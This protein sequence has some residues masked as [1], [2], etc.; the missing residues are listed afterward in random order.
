MRWTW[1]A[2]AFLSAS[3]LF[4][5]GYYHDPN[6]AVW[7]VLVLAGTGLLIGIDFRT[8]TRIE[9]VVAAVFSENRRQPNA[10]AEIVRTREPGNPSCGPWNVSNVACCPRQQLLDVSLRL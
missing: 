4:G 2:L 5:S 6:W 1:I 3:W 8:P 7:A 9:S 10:P